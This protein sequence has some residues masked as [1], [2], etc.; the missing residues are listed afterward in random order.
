MNEKG[1]KK[2]KKNTMEN[3][4]KE[5]KKERKRKRI[6]KNKREDFKKVNINLKGQEIFEMRRQFFLQISGRKEVMT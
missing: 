4:L 2:R 5:R 3:E 6:K 1:E